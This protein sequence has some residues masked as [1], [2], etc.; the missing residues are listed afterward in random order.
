MPIK[1]GTV[2]TDPLARGS[3]M[4]GGP[5]A[6][7]SVVEGGPLVRG[8]GVVEGGNQSEERVLD[9][10]VITV[11]AVEIVTDFHE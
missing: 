3:V 4:E 5:L 6:R 7:G 9:C 1:R 8:S 10:C 2:Q 11:I